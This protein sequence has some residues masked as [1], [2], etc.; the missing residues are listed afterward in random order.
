VGSISA[1]FDGDEPHAPRGSFAEA[2]SVGE[3]TRILSTYLKTSH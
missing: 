3:I 2:R 1:V